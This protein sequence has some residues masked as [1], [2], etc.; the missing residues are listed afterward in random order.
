MAEQASQP[1]ALDAHMVRNYGRA[2]EVFVDGCGA[3]LRTTEGVVY[4]DFLGGIGVSALGHGHPDLAAALADQAGRTLHVSNLFRHPYTVEV[5]TRLAHLTGLE[6]VLF[7]NSGAEAN[8]AALKLARKHQRDAGRPE[9]T[10]FVAL[11]GG[12]HGRTM[13]ALSVTSGASYRAPFEPMVP[14]TRFLPSGDLDAMR[15][16][17]A[18]DRPAAVILEPIQGEGG[19]VELSPEYLRGVRDLCDA[20]DTVLIHDEVQSG[21]GRTGTFLAADAAG[22]K[23]DVVTLAKPLAAGLPMGAIVVRA[24]LADVLKPGDHGSTFAG[25]P[26]ALRAAL[27]FLTLLED[28]GLMERAAELGARLK[29]GLEAIAADFPNVGAVRGRG[30]M[31]GLHI[32]KGAK[33]LQQ[34]LYR[35]HHLITNCTAGEVIRMLPPYV[36]TES[37]IDDALGRIRS[38]LGSLELDAP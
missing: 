22:I 2:D 5:A 34:R 24:E 17:L 14:G 38:A 27:V 32:P 21:C 19:V 31:L 15:V 10:G 30:L 7:T 13:G 9:R 1:Q 18:R 11:E 8:E 26:L 29:T 28:D 36:V 20:T 33:E 4:L 6:A 16:T 35:D 23:P 3:E 25:G 12:F 37:Q